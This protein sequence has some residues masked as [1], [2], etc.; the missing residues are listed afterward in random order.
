LDRG[1]IIQASW[2][3]SDTPHSAEILWPN[4]Q[5]DAETGLH[6]NTQQSQD[7]DFH[8]PFGIRTR[9]PNN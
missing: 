8:A 5:P 3:H 6:D 7:T 9:N 4:D 2:S 1:L